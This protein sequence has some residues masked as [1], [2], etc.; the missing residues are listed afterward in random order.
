MYRLLRTI[1]PLVLVFYCSVCIVG[2]CWGEEGK[3]TAKV[4]VPEKAYPGEII[5]LSVVIEREIGNGEKM[6][7][8]DEGNVNID[9][10]EG[11]AV[12]EEPSQ[13]TS[14]GQWKYKIKSSYKEDTYKILVNYTPKGS[15]KKIAYSYTIKIFP[16]MVLFTNTG[17]LLGA[18]TGY[19]NGAASGSYS[20]EYFKYNLGGA[21]LGLF[22]GGFVGGLVGT[23][24]DKTIDQNESMARGFYYFNYPFY[25]FGEIIG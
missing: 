16:R 4:E 10:P 20:G 24:I 21:V 6:L 3:I 2:T 22:V 12:K 5:S 7:I 8:I 1:A 19:M 15:D 13:A 14:K 17:I 18:Y 9:V 25:L 11:F 23:I